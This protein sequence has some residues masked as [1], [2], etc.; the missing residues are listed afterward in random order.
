MIIDKLENI[1]MYRPLLNYL[2]EGL[3]AITAQMVQLEVGRYE[4]EH[5][6]FLVQKGETKPMA[7][8]FYEAHQKYVDIQIIMAGSEEV[9]WLDLKDLAEETPYNLK[10]DAAYYSGDTS[11]VMR[12]TEGMFYIAFPHDG[13]RPVRHTEVQQTFTKI[14]L[15]LPVAL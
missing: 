7:E 9:A 1:K 12:I 15:K 2:E 13:H 5:G 6:F 10:K 11:H 3:N 4:F 14:V 8:G